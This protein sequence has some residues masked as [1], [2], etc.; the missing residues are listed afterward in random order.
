M[1]CVVYGWSN[2]AIKGMDEIVQPQHSLQGNQKGTWHG[3]II[4][5]DFFIR[6]ITPNFER[7]TTNFLQ[8]NRRW[9][10]L[11]GR[12][13]NDGSSAIPTKI[14]G[15]PSTNVWERER[16]TTLRLCLTTKMNMMNL[17]LKENKFHQVITS[18][19]W[20]R[21]LCW[22]YKEVHRCTC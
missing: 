11:H 15:N 2:G 21:L 8:R 10:R 13:S 7:E 20:G 18:L 9:M 12:N 22:Y 5:L 14:C 17:S 19:V 6:Q 1:D 3:D 4:I 16:Y